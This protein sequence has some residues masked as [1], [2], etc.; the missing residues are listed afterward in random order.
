M[1]Q[2]HFTDEETGSEEAMTSF[3][4][5]LKSFKMEFEPFKVICGPDTTFT[6]QL[7]ATPAYSHNLAVTFHNV[8]SGMGLFVQLGNDTHW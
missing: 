4:L 6:M 1:P 5:S 2:S 8:P 7:V 3:V